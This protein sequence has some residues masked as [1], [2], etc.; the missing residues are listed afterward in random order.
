MHD[1]KKFAFLSH[2]SKTEIQESDASCTEQ[3][4]LPLMGR[5][6]ANE[7]LDAPVCLN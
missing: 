2:P 4:L 3:Y 7:G 1:K 6:I 5:V